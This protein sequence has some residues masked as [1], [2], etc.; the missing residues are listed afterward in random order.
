MGAPYL[1]VFPGIAD[2]I[3]W[4]V[5]RVSNDKSRCFYTYQKPQDQYKKLLNTPKKLV[6]LHLCI[7]CGCSGPEVEKV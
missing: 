4:G 2:W 3:F 5:V 7:K 6:G 1:W